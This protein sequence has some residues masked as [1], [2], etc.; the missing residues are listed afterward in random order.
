MSLWKT[1]K[2]IIIRCFLPLGNNLFNSD[3][4]L[5]SSSCFTIYPIYL[6]FFPTRMVVTA[7]FFAFHLSL[8]NTWL[9]VLR[10]FCSAVYFWAYTSADKEV[11]M[12][13]RA[14]ASPALSSGYKVLIRPVLLWKQTRTHSEKLPVEYGYRIEWLSKE[15]HIVAIHYLHYGKWLEWQQIVFYHYL[16]TNFQFTTYIKNHTLDINSRW[17]ASL[18]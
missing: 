2:H 10:V 15:T 4:P 11:F 6:F 14:K 7:T 16:S 17:I 8:I 12:P 18:S 5:C 3:V 1:N 13:F 9:V